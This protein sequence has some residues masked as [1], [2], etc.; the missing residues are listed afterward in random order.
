MFFKRGE[1]DLSRGSPEGGDQ[2]PVDVGLEQ[3]NA[4]PNTQTL[5]RT[6]P[7]YNPSPHRSPGDTR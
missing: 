5:P 4:G 1:Y 6:Y 3:A 7:P 2:P